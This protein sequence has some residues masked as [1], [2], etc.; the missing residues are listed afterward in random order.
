MT[1]TEPAAMN[2]GLQ[3]IHGELDFEIDPGERGQEWSASNGRVCMSVL[4]SERNAEPSKRVRDV[5]AL[6]YKSQRQHFPMGGG[7]A[8]PHKTQVLIGE[9]NGVFVHVQERDGRTHIVVAD[10]R[11]G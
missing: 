2:G 7:G 5:P 3:F 11:M 9:L 1:D 8:V 10:K 6:L 4:P